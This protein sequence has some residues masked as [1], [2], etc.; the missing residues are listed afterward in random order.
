MAVKYSVNLRYLTRTSNFHF[1]SEKIA[2]HFSAVYRVPAST[3]ITLES[4][5]SDSETEQFVAIRYADQLLTDEIDS[6]GACQCSFTATSIEKE[7][8]IEIQPC[9]VGIDFEISRT[10]D[11]SNS[12]TECTCSE[13]SRTMSCSGIKEPVRDRWCG[14]SFCCGEESKC[15][16]N[17]PFVT[18]SLTAGSVIIGL[19]AAIAVAYC[20]CRRKNSVIQ[21]ILAGRRKVAVAQQIQAQQTISVR[22]MLPTT[23]PTPEHSAS[24]ITD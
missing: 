16:E 9:T 3:S 20:C 11:E 12:T 14:S 8:F 7:S 2:G 6:S 22:T 21:P 18:G 24:R 19:G 13:S 5:T 17:S 23:T 10:C 1:M 4:C 15:C